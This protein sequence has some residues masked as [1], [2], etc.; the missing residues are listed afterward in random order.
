MGFDRA[1]DA[2]NSPDFSVC[3]GVGA[4]SRF[5]HEV[6]GPEE[7]T[8]K[9]G[10][11]VVLFVLEASAGEHVHLNLVPDLETRKSS[12]EILQ[13]RASSINLSEFFLLYQVI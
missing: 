5:L 7:Q 3:Q 11:V 2:V 9:L 6:L 8:H 12:V 10:Q 1:K 4:W 13:L